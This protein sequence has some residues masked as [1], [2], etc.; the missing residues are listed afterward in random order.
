VHSTRN[1]GRSGEGPDQ[2]GA[3]KRDNLTFE[4]ALRK[5]ERLLGG[6]G[7]GEK[8]RSKAKGEKED[9]VQTIQVNEV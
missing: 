7:S 1:L 5:S 4:R 6:E 3:G 9:E 8:P 2:G